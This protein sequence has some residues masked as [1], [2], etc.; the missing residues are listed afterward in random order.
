MQE[1]FKFRLNPNPKKLSNIYRIM[2]KYHFL[3][4]V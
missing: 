3:T 4:V 1:L 2:I